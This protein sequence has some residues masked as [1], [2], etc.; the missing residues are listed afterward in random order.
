MGTTTTLALVDGTRI[1]VVDSLS[2]LTP[3]VLREQEDWFEDEIRFLRKVLQPGSHV[4]DVGANHGIYTLSMARAVGAAGRVWAFE[5]TPATAQLLAAGIAC[6][7]CGHVLLEQLALS[8][9]CG[10]GQLSVSEHS[11]LNALVQGTTSGTAATVL[12]STLDDRMA[13]HD[14]QRI[15]FIKIDAE[16]EEGRILRGGERFLERF[17]AL[18]QYEIKAD[19]RVPLIR[20]FA[21]RGYDSYRLVPG[22]DLLVPIDADT[23]PDD[24]LLNLFAC[25]PERAGQL[26]ARGYLVQASAPQETPS[27]NWRHWLTTTV[28]GAQ[29]A[30]LW[31]GR[32]STEVEF[33]L[34]LYAQSRDSSQ[35]PASRF[36]ALA[37]S[38]RRLESVCAREPS[39]LRL[40]SLA[41]AARDYGART[42][43][44]RAL[45]QLV[46]ALRNTR[47]VDPSEPFLVPGERFDSIAPG[48]APFKWVLAAALE[49]FERLVAFSSFY[50]GL[51]ARS[52]LETIQSLGFGS[53]EMQR[54][55]RLLQ[56]RFD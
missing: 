47:R 48:A 3:Y 17:S 25:K 10:T 1:V 39:G 42:I 30:D 44:V 31:A 12:L 2:L 13:R 46:D 49:E 11:E 15:D 19:T 20:D 41:R 32:V 34:S 6:N 45:S 33:A 8:D 14:W 27:S 50:T 5:P 55:L 22:L 16:G 43:A 28:Y 51:D 56:Q 21:A 26:A 40:M 38:L 36:A 23:V 52:R 4:I 53:P 29:L 18:V 7:D 35:P 54:R 9:R 37:A 24:Y